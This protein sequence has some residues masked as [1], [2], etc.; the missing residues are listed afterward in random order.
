MQV[1]GVIFEVYYLLLFDH[2]D[3]PCEDS[4]LARIFKHNHIIYNDTIPYYV[5]TYARLNHYHNW[6]SAL[7]HCINMSRLCQRN[8]LLS[9]VSI[10]L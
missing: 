8:E 1:Y 4:N 3:I 10:S 9:H 5:S 7:I 6:F 2:V